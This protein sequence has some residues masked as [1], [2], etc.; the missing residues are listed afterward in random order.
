[1]RWH[2]AWGESR[3]LWV[4]DDW[5][6]VLLAE[7]I[8][9]A[10]NCCFRT[11]SVIFTLLCSIVCEDRKKMVQGVAVL[12]PCLWAQLIL[13]TSSAF[14]G[15]QG[16]GEGRWQEKATLAPEILSTLFLIMWKKLQN[17]ECPGRK[18]NCSNFLFLFMPFCGVLESACI[19]PVTSL[20]PFR[21]ML[22]PGPFLR[23]H[24]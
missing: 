24:V 14:Y 2:L 19:F 7:S 1:M 17:L 13:H 21:G 11:H 5:W 16:G 15:L 4:Q 12:S 22:L 10:Y 6:M 8:Q 18:K 20:S 23:V 9:F 3:I